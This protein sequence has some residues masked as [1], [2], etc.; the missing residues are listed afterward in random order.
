[1]YFY[2]IFSCK[3]ICL[4]NDWPTSARITD[5]SSQMKYSISVQ[6]LE[7]HLSMSC[8]QNYVKYINSCPLCA[9]MHARTHA[10]THTHTHTPQFLFVSCSLVDEVFGS[11]FD[12]SASSHVML[13]I[14]FKLI[15]G[16]N[17]IP[18]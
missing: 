5:N 8:K 12:S 16:L 17:S 7:M 9:C 11:K 18:V 10:R 1:M 13:D 6:K 15:S 4:T 14:P 3:I 2:R